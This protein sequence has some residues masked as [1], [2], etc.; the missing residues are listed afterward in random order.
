MDIRTGADCVG[1]KSGWDE[2]GI[3]Y[4]QSSSG[5]VVR[6][7]HLRC[8]RCSALSIGSEMSGGVSDVLYEDVVI[9]ES[10]AGFRLKTAPGRGGYV[11]GIALRNIVM[12][13][14][15]VA[16]SFLPLYGQHA[17]D[18]YDP[19][20]LP[21]VSNFTFENVSGCEISQAGILEG[22][23]TAPFRQIHITHVHLDLVE[24]G[25]GFSCRDVNGTAKDVI[26]TICK[27]LQP[28]IRI[29]DDAIGST[30]VE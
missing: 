28:S 1:I 5:V 16:I 2:Y 6:G 13:K 18:R 24:G 25:Q 20:A 22:L 12:E 8:V 23:P 3:R 29:R 15:G 9:L 10:Q 27:E 17:D 11:Q 4:N 26:P 14:V 7:C 21:L 30:H 19:T